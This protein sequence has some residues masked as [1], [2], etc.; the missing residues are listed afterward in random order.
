MRARACARNSKLHLSSEIGKMVTRADTRTLLLNLRGSN[1][2]HGTER[3]DR[4]AS[5]SLARY[6]IVEHF[7]RTSLL[8]IG[9]WRQ[10]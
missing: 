7:I 3:I 1:C 6:R 4:Q 8:F 5:E 2:K 9:V 10:I